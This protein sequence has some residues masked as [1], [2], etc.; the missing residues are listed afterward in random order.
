MIIII[1]GIRKEKYNY[2]YIKVI[3]STFGLV[4]IELLYVI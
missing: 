4:S 3:N 1:T 2:N